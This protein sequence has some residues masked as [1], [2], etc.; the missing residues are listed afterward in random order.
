[1]FVRPHTLKHVF[2]QVRE[3]L[4]RIYDQKEAASVAL[5]LFDDILRQCNIKL[6]TD[7]ELRLSKNILS[8]LEARL[9]HLMNHRPL[10]YVL[11]KAEFYGMEFLVNESVLI[12]RPETEELVDLINK[13][14]QE[15]GNILD[16]GTGSGC[17]AIALASD[18]PR[19][20]VRAMDI[21]DEAL[22]IAKKNAQLN[23]AEVYF[24][25]DDIL[26]PHAGYGKFDVIVS[27][28]PYVLEKEK[29]L[30]NKNVL[31]Y[32]PH[33]ALFVG[34]EDPLL[35]YRHIILFASDHLERGGKLY[36]EINE[37]YGE[38]IKKLLESTGFENTQIIRDLSGRDR[39]IKASA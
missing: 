12:P 2:T 32:E 14:Y 36:F 28:P 34:D 18:K 25:K 19:C 20:K 24:I 26:N 7:P 13:E 3:Q 21:S 39:F 30:I 8:S 38:E 35:F 37:K 6:I 9:N 23:A 15:E 27:N 10:Q 4:T 11:G 33:L 29:Q 17:I 1:M 22:A 31:D 16:I 5:R